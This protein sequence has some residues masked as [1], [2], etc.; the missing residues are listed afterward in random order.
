MR[1]APETPTTQYLHN[2]YPLSEQG[3]KGIEN[4]KLLVSSSIEDYETQTLGIIGYCARPGQEHAPEI[5]LESGLVAKAHDP[6]DGLVTLHRGPMWKP[7]SDP[8]EWH[9]IET[10]HPEGAYITMRDQAEVYANLAVEVRHK[11]HLQRYGHLLSFMWTGG[12]SVN[13]SELMKTVALENPSIPLGIKND[14][15]GTIDL[16]LEQIEQVTALRGKDGAPAILI[17]RGGLKASSPKAWEEAVMYVHERT[18]GRFILDTAH[19]AEMAHDPKRKFGKSVDGQVLAAYAMNRLVRQ[20]YAPAGSMMEA[21]ELKSRTD[22][23]MPL[24][25]ALATIKEQHRL[26]K[27]PAEPLHLQL[28]ASTYP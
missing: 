16:A 18:K 1:Q 28:Q 7:R 19:G 15:D 8:S 12:R 20:G 14:L 23:H 5:M 25:I 11:Y 27:G 3:A 6:E 21:S 2:R 4:M 26:K 22:P 13:D 9:G 10:T 24:Y 17:Y